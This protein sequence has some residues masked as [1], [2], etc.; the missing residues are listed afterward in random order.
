[1][2]W[3]CLALPELPLEA[4]FRG[5]P[6]TLPQR[7][8][9]VESGQRLLV[10]QADASADTA[11]VRPGQTLSAA[12]ALLPTLQAQAR[13]PA[14]ED[15]MHQHLA[16][17]AYGFSSHVV[18]LPAQDALPAALALE[19]GGSLRLFGGWPHLA[20]LLRAGL[21]ALGHCH[22]LAAAP[23]L[24]GARVL[25]SIAEHDG[26]AMADTT[27]LQHALTRL[28]LPEAGLSARQVSALQ[29]M[30]L[31][32]L[33]DLFALPRPELAR[34]LG[35]PLLLWLDRLRGQALEAYEPYRPATRFR[36]RIA[37]DY[38]ID[39]HMALQFALRRLTRELAAFVFARAGGVQ[40]FTLLFEHEGRPSSQLEIGLRQALSAPE[41]LFDA[42]RGRL[43]HASLPA[44][45]VG[46]GLHADD[47]PPLAPERRDLFD[48]TP[49]GNLDL[50]GLIERLRARLGDEA[51][52]NLHNYPDHRP[53][54]AWRVAEG[55]PPA[56]APTPFRPHWLLPRPIP[57]RQRIARILR[58]PER[59]ETGWWDDHDI[60][61]DYVIAELDSG[62]HAW[63]FR[64]AGSE[65]AWML[66][67][68]FA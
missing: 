8:V 40:H 15:S 63:L 23:T 30:G 47:L 56:F 26:L 57:L 16:A 18:C 61:R 51:V 10:V 25:A 50:P 38:G 28:A 36:Q 66:H 34:R 37:F 27:Q 6:Q 46:L 64:E 58:G 22:S 1:M 41:A 45:V 5:D 21:H 43:E 20:G 44:A 62:Q 39:N 55:K 2:L 33:G 14:T 59:L 60:R 12:R 24:A 31:R 35:P 48:P 53:E 52:C 11:G 13:Q 7:L 9:Y 49:H 32:R 3:A 68:W 54:R 19:V 17:W 65:G 42:A 4:A 67:G 29:A